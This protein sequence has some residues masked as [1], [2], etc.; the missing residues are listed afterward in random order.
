MSALVERTI[1]T[2]LVIY[3]I[4]DYLGIDLDKSI[5]SQ[6]YGDGESDD[7]PCPLY[8]MYTRFKINLT[9]I[10]LD[11]EIIFFATKSEKSG[12]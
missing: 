10:R 7:M 5:Y 3:P 2:G 6:I 11:F 4:Y 9:L 1:L 12:V 8:V